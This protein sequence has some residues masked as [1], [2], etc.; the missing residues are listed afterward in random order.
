MKLFKIHTIKAIPVL[1]VLV[2]SVT[3]CDPPSFYSLT[4]SQP[5][6]VDTLSVRSINVYIETSVSMAGYVNS[7]VSGSYPLKDVIPFMIT[8]LNKS[9]P[10]EANLFTISD[11]QRKITYSKNQFYQ[12]LRQGTIFTGKS[13]KL[14]NIFNSVLSSLDNGTVSILITDGIPDLGKENAKTEGSKIT[15][16]L[17]EG[18]STKGNLGVAL[19]QY[20]SDFNGTHYYDRDNTGGKRKSERPY[21][22][23]TLR[24]RPFY[25]WVFGPKMLVQEFLS[26]GIIKD[27][28]YS[29][30][31]NIPLAA[32]PFELL[33]QPKSGK[34]STT[35]GENKLLIKAVE[36]RLPALF[37]IGMNLNGQ[38]KSLI[39]I[40]ENSN[41]YHI[42]PSFIQETIKI[43]VKDNALLSQNFSGHVKLNITNKG[44]TH[45]L[46]PTLYDFDP[47][48]ETITFGLYNKQP[49]WI[50]TTHLEDDLEKSIDSL[51]RRTF[52][53]NY[54]TKAFERAFKNDE[55][56]LEFTL[57]KI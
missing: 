19:F 16:E 44:Y 43:D 7:N 36:E 21:Y 10:F 57:T 11:R 5:E 51:E 17:Y 15:S 54:I 27:H 2:F 55:S 26:K 40:A 46:Q 20:L 30:T 33:E 45:F 42:D 8:D 25:V 29:H 48:T 32:V 37:T 1:F 50:N 18:L 6:Y 39:K 22:Q 23:I 3:A 28:T 53:F 41:N 12:K 9:Y 13:S 4:S 24:N 38:A 14:Q 52:G 56:L 31:Y 49:S 47:D 35:S 34:I